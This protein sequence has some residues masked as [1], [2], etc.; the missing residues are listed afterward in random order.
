MPFCSSCQIGFHYDMLVHILIHV[1]ITELRRMKTGIRG[2]RPGLTQTGLH[3]QG[4]RLEAS[5]FGYT[6]RRNCTIGV[7]KTKAMIS[8]AVPAKLICA[9][10]F[11]IGKKLVFS[12][13]GS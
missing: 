3:S 10:C 11:R 12:W 6:Q 13:R 7:A 8:F 5:D 2:F 4:S 1:D 9:F